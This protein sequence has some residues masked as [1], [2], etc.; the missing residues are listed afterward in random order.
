MLSGAL[1]GRY[2]LGYLRSPPRHRLK[3]RL[4]SERDGPTFPV[5]GVCKL[6]AIAESP[7]CLVC[8][9]AAVCRF[10]RRVG[11]SKHP[12][13]RHSLRM[14]DV[15][16]LTGTLERLLSMAHV[17]GDRIGRWKISLEGLITDPGASPLSGLVILTRKETNDNNCVCS[18]DG[19]DLFKTFLQSEFSEENL[20]FWQSCE[21]LKQLRGQALEHTARQIFAKFL[22]PDAPSEVSFSPTQVTSV[23]KLMCAIKVNVDAETHKAVTASLTSPTPDM[24]NKAQ[25]VIYTL[26][27]RDSYRRFLKSNDFAILEQSA[28]SA[29]QTQ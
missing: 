15:G 9:N 4:R 13:R 26:M 14:A 11:K 1:A 20:Q 19:A 8:S 18:L 27:E 17:S 7:S 3:L 16:E 6:P 12:T 21:A 5:P 24:F 2:R 23:R 22:E 29:S 28:Q 25:Q 10:D